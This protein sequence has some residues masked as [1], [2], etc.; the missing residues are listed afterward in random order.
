MYVNKVDH[1]ARSGARHYF[2]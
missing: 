1:K 2:Q